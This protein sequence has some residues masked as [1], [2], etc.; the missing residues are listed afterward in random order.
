MLAWLAAVV[1][2]V[3]ISAATFFE[4]I[5]KDRQAVEGALIVDGLG[6]LLHSAAIPGEPSSVDYDGTARIAED[7]AEK[8]ILPRPTNNCRFFDVVLSFDRNHDTIC[9]SL[10]MCFPRNP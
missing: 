1:E 7:A 4:S 6:Y 8:L 10:H 5:R 2:D 9:N 3:G